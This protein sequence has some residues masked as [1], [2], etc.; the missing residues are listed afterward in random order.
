MR[1]DNENSTFWSGRLV[2]VGALG[3]GDVFG[4]G[5]AMS[6]KPPHTPPGRPPAMQ[7]TGPVPAH[8]VPRSGRLRTGPRAPLIVGQSHRGVR[9]QQACIEH[10]V[11]PHGGRTLTRT[12]PPGLG[13]EGRRVGRG[14]SGRMLSGRLSVPCA[15]ASRSASYGRRAGGLGVCACPHA[16][17]M[18]TVWDRQGCT[19]SD[20]GYTTAAL[21]CVRSGM[22]TVWG[23]YCHH[24]MD[25]S[26]TRSPWEQVRCP[27]QSHPRLFLAGGRP[28]GSL[29]PMHALPSTLYPCVSGVCCCCPPDSD[30]SPLPLR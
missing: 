19:R 4:R 18:C 8:P 21:L 23:S 29:C 16:H 22:D 1:P 13:S 28:E 3:R 10:E 24:P 11:K 14:P 26:L 5:T 25:L 6:S 27:S 15:Q 17:H 30:C 2:M 20:A 7:R 9:G 12:Q